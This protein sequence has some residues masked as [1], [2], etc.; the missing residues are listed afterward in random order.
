LLTTCFFDELPDFFEFCVN[1]Q[2]AIIIAGDFN[3]H[4]DNV[5]DTNTT[6]L[7]NQLD[8]FS[9]IQTVKEPTHTSGHTLDLVLV[10]A[11]EN[12]VYSTRTYHDLSSDHFSILCHLAIKKPTHTSKVI[13]SR[14]FSKINHDQFAIDLAQSLTPNM[15]VY[16]LNH[17]LTAVLDSHAPVRQRKVRESK[18]TP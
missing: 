6:K 3:F 11:L 2:T 18:P 7:C 4:F 8:M 1:C 14:P 10:K 5:L 16:D 17:A 15:S 9:L 12:I 13:S